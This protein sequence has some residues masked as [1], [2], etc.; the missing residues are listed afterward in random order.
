[1]LFMFFWKMHTYVV[2]TRNIHTCY[3][4]MY[5]Y[6][7]LVKRPF[8]LGQVVNVIRESRSHQ[9]RTVPGCR[10]LTSHIT[11]PA[12]YSS[13][14]TLVIRKE[15]PGYQ[16]LKNA[17]DLPLTQLSHTCKRLIMLYIACC[18]VNIYVLLVTKWYE[19][20]FVFSLVSIVLFSFVKLIT[21]FCIHIY[22]DNTIH[23]CKHIKSKSVPWK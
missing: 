13:G 9:S 3:H 8:S 6:V 17:P 7:N 16:E 22:T 1:M 19:N 12:A 14:I 4:S 10:N 21:F 23:F 2:H 18:K 20:D 11:I 5:I 15:S